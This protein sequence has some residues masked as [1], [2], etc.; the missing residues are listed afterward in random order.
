MDLYAENILDHYRSPRGKI[1]IAHPTV[2]HKES[3]PACGDVLTVQISLKDDQTVNIGWD[4]EGC[5][6]SQSAMSMIFEELNGETIEEAESIS[7]QTMYGLLGIPISPRRTKCALLAL[8]VLKNT[9]R[10][11]K[12]ED[13]QSWSKTIGEKKI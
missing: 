13:P 3:N 7:T 11:L 9:F 5:A 4:G 1:F 8:H 10:K 2:E 6:I 12:K